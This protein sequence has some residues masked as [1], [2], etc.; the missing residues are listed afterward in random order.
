[1]P[2]LVSDSMTLDL[3]STQSASGLERKWPRSKV[4]CWASEVEMLVGRPPERVETTGV[5]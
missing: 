2:G 4:F 1:M 3:P 5:V